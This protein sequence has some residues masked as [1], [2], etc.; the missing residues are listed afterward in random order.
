[1]SFD[2]SKDKTKIKDIFM[3]STFYSIRILKLSYSYFEEQTSLSRVALNRIIKDK[4]E[5]TKR[6]SIW[7]SHELNC[8]DYSFLKR[9]RK[10]SEKANGNL[11][12]Y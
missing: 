7:V 11:I 2:I 12:K 6:S 9:Y 5:L 3:F 10:S 8:K 1:M 4:S